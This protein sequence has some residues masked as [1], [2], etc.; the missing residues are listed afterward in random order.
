MASVN[1]MQA[2]REAIE[3][4]GGVSAVIR[5]IANHRSDDE[6]ALMLAGIEAATSEQPAADGPTFCSSCANSVFGSD[7]ELLHDRRDAELAKLRAERDHWED[8]YGTAA[9]AIIEASGLNP[10]GVGWDEAI[11]KIT[12]D[13]DALKAKLAAL[14]AVC[15]PVVY[16]LRGTPC[17]MCH[18]S[19]WGHECDDTPHPRRK[20]LEDALRAAKEVR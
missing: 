5:A 12:A 2:A 15:E 13:R 3:R 1:I 14:V 16:D 18:D 9:T 10:N 7:G 8:E 6:R 17:S 11:Q 20:P 19:T 4:N